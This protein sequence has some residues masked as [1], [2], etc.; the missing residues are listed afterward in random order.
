MGGLSNYSHASPQFE[1]TQLI[2]LGCKLV[3]ALSIGFS[4]IVTSLLSMRFLHSRNLSF[5]SDDSLTRG[6]EGSLPSVEDCL[7]AMLTIAS[8]SHT[9]GGL[10]FASLED[11]VASL[12]WGLYFFLDFGQWRPT[13]LIHLSQSTIN[14]LPP[15]VN[16]SP[17]LIY[18]LIYDQFTS[19]FDTAFCVLKISLD[20]HFC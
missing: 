12:L 16:L 8:S 3:N 15:V 11:F 4:A 19:W 6:L 14:N 10:R 9:L 18:I 5:H 17:K 2:I 13:P 20:R 7:M 1:V